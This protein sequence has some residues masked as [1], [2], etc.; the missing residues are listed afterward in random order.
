MNRA[1]PVVRLRVP[2]DEDA[3]AWHR[4]FDDPDVM[5]FHG[6]RSAEVSAYEE[7]TARQRRHD[8]EYGFCFWTML[9][10]SDQV[11]GFTGAQPWPQDWGPK[12]EIEIGWRLGRAHWG[13]GY[14]T[15]A[16]ELTLERVRAAGVPSVV[17]MVNAR[18]ERSIAV[19]RRLGMRL[20]E[21]FR[22]P[23]SKQEGHCYRLDL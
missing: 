17:A 2:T 4:V 11:I 6:G 5:E 21:V 18:N 9:D 1:L 23:V 14:A 10:E 19:T 12:G 22:T 3:F 20:V 15:A 13:Q 16:A 7:L 8:A